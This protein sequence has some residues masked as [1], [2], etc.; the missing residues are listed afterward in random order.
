MH[1]NK[2][3]MFMLIAIA[4]LVLCLIVNMN[5]ASPPSDTSG[6]VPPPDP[7]P[8]PPPKPSPSEGGIKFNLNNG[9]FNQHGMSLNPV[10]PIVYQLNNSDLYKFKTI[11][12]DKN[13]VTMKQKD[14]FN[15]IAT[16]SQGGQISQTW[17]Y[18]D[19]KQYDGKTISISYPLNES[20]GN[21]P[22]S[23]IN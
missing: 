2:S 8:S 15:V 18:D 16:T 7:K 1:L 14:I 23:V 19:L 20:L 22:I 17:V 13:P 5:Q 11:N 10:V 6:S 9:I 4:L 21:F 3:L 12:S